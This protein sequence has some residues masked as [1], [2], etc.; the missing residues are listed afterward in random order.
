MALKRMEKQIMETMENKKENVILPEDGA[1]TVEVTLE[2][3]SGRAQITSP[4]ELVML[5]PK[6]ELSKNAASSWV[7]MV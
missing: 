1:Y 7:C 5:E 3:G 6:L 2:G 4:A